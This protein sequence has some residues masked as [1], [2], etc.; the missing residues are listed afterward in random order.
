LQAYWLAYLLGDYA[1]HVPD[2]KM[3]IALDDAV[4]GA[5]KVVGLGKVD[6]GEKDKS[7]S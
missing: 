5:P 2:L 4:R 3:L 7:R 6:E 1:N